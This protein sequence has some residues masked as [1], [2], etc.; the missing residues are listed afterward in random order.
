MD[1]SSTGAWAAT[2]SLNAL[3][4]P[5]FAP[6]KLSLAVAIALASPL[7]HAQ[8]IEPQDT[9]TDVVEAG[10]GRL[11]AER[12]DAV[13]SDG[14][15]TGDSIVL[16]AVKVGASADASAGGL[17]KVLP[18]GQVARGSRI[19]ILGGRDA[20]DT[21]F[22]VTSYT[23]RLIRDQQTQGVGSVLQN[24]PSVRTARG[25][26][27][28]QESYF[29][30]GFLLGSDDI[31]YNGLHGVLPRQYV[32]SELFER[33]ELL[34]GASTF[35]TGATPSG[36]GAGG[37]INL[38][39]KRAPNDPLNQVDIGIANNEQF[40]ISADLARRVG[41]DGDTGLRLNATHRQGGTGIDHEDVE[42][43]LVS[44]AVDWRDSHTRLSADIGHQNH[45]LK[46]A[47]TNVTLA[48]TVT[49]VPSAPD[50]TTNWA[51]PWSHSNEKATFGT[52]RGEHDFN[53]AIT[54]WFA[55]GARRSDEENS[56]GNLTIDQNDG[57]GS[58]YRFDNGRKDQVASGEL[59]L[60]G[61]FATGAVGHEVVVSLAYYKVRKDNGYTYDMGTTQSTNLYSPVRYV[62]VPFTDTAF[63]G[64]SVSDPK[65][66][67][68]T[69]LSSIA[70]GDTLS[71]L[72]DRALLTLGAR[73][74][75]LKDETYAYDT[76]ELS[77]TYD[78]SRTSP[79]VGLVYKLPENVS[80]YTNYIESLAQGDTA[81]ATSG[82]VAVVNAGEQLS[83]YVAK[84]KE[85]GL[86]YDSGRA[87]FA[88][89]L[90][91]TDRPRSFVDGSARFTSAG[92]DRHQGAELTVQGEPIRGLK[93]LGGIMLLDAKQRATG[94]AETDGKRVIG[95]PRRQASLALDWSLP[96][97][98]GL[99]ADVRLTSSGGSKADAANT[100]T[101]PGWSR[102]DLGARYEMDV[103]GNLVTLRA[104]ID[105]LTDRKYW[106][107]V[108]G[109]PGSGYLVQ[110]SPRTFSL[111]ASVEF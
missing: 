70:I 31:A 32:A 26:G 99:S 44:A 56:L 87:L 91:S 50:S 55:L 68:K 61:K 100:L 41:P 82:G 57:D 58:F 89:A 47:R 14:V 105:N 25:F 69:R 10:D 8:L 94:S 20:M 85:I 92:K 37:N 106:S 28:F 78:K 15:V 60:R 30:R 40:H 43:D 98:T 96:W 4:A 75:T 18:G 42:L 9:E 80:V 5:A 107:S 102:I 88:L 13:A 35:L 101:A 59:G 108:G 11:M 63:S 86:K 76:G 16:D 110:G 84:Q 39:P 66:N 1:T 17:S 3:R 79:M 27:N 83:P 81:P 51:Q 111:S 29:I 23:N 109:Y 38:L 33:V 72:D 62:S 97:V 48:S 34:R 53:D 46:E 93:V 22:S 73:H 65:L 36:G 103:Q 104:R 12:A 67:G 52:L 24:D 49:A 71:F 77:S 90:F 64:N 7:A 6:Q 95:V 74:Q 21:P 2:A 19:G 45:R 54:G